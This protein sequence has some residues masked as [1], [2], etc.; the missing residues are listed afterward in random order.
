MIEYFGW[1]T[2]SESTCEAE[3]DETALNE[4][5]EEV[6]PLVQ[7]LNRHNTFAELRYF[8][9]LPRVVVGGANNHKA[10]AWPEVL[11]LFE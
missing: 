3:D 1:C 7:K 2:I 10:Q 6:R 5:V 4:I 8:N 9:G 11:G